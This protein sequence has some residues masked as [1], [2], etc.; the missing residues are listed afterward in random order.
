MPYSSF[1]DSAVLNL[2]AERAFATRTPAK[3]P[4]SSDDDLSSSQRRNTHQ[5]QTEDEEIAVRRRQLNTEAARRARARNKAK[6]VELESQVTELSLKLKAALERC[7]LYETQ[8]SLLR[9]NQPGD[10]AARMEYLNELIRVRDAKIV[11]LTKGTGALEAQVMS[12]VTEIQRLSHQLHEAQ[13]ECMAA[14]AREQQTAQR[15]RACVAE[16]ERLQSEIDRLSSAISLTSMRNQSSQP[17]PP[18]LQPPQ[19]ERELQAQLA[20][21]TRQLESAER[22]VDQ[23]SSSIADL[24]SMVESLLVKSQ[25][26]PSPSDKTHARSTLPLYT[27]A[28][29]LPPLPAVRLPR[30]VQSIE[31]GRMLSPPPTAVGSPTVSSVLGKRRHTPGAAPEPSPRSHSPPIRTKS[32]PEIH[33]IPDGRPAPPRVGPSAP[34]LRPVTSFNSPSFSRSG[35]SSRRMS[36]PSSPS[37]PRLHL[38]TPSSFGPP[39]GDSKVDVKVN[40]NPRDLSLDGRRDDIWDGGP[41]REFASR[42]TRQYTAGQRLEVPLQPPGG[43]VGPGTHFDG[44]GAACLEGPG[45]SPHFD[46]RRAAFERRTEIERRE[47]RRA[48][49]E[50]RGDVDLDERRPRR[51]VA[52]QE[53]PPEDVLNRVPPPEP[54]QG[55]YVHLPVPQPEPATL[56]RRPEF[57][58]RAGDNGGRLVDLSP[59]FIPPPPN[60]QMMKRSD[61]GSSSKKVDASSLKVEG[62][63]TKGDLNG[64]SASKRTQS[65][66]SAVKSDGKANDSKADAA[67]VKQEAIPIALDGKSHDEAN[68]QFA[69]PK[70]AKV[71][72][73]DR[74]FLHV[75]DL[76]WYTTVPHNNWRSTL[77]DAQWDGSTTTTATSP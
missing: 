29:V 12:R 50:R 18:P 38:V 72:D 33:T 23:L 8:N 56:D 55:H 70:L 61:P 10:T 57:E 77:V 5:K 34:L 59:D 15:E 45:V 36:R 65:E 19:M 76:H 4:D 73:L 2:D 26:A 9:N 64:K 7:D 52:E 63:S 60:A 3:D 54:P 42:P 25:Q 75:H 58:R 32:S 44:P 66:S 17:T 39:H 16:K 41:P 21:R 31:M 30:P 43:L 49:P 74:G 6:L 51:S 67:T 13:Q 46:P 69:K 14:Q 22:E 28:R 47:F 48:D 68:E 11:E 40:G 27:S 1:G 20:E 53:Q 24:R 62:T 71:K 35:Q 37:V